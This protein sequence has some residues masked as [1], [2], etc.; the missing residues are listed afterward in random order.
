MA[1]HHPLRHLHDSTRRSCGLP[2]ATP[3]AHQLPP[4]QL[5]WLPAAG[6]GPRH[7]TDWQRQQLVELPHLLAMQACMLLHQPTTAAALPAAAA[8]PPLFQKARQAVQQA[9]GWHRRP[10][11]ALPL[12]LMLQ[13]QR[14]LQHQLL[15]PLGRHGRG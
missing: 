9:S 14:L 11:P 5:Q 12:M 4:A 6:I 1:Q 15:L 3:N 10:L 7:P 2:A 8:L 13:H